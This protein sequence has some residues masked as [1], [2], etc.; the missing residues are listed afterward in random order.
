MSRQMS[1]VH[2]ETRYWR[3]TRRH[4]MVF[5]CLW[6]VL[7]FGLLF[8]AREIALYSNWPLAVFVLVQVLMLAYLILIVLFNFMIQ[9]LRRKRAGAQHD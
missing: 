7:N 4:T 6:L 1:G 3:A 8:F 9:R 5:C 2:T